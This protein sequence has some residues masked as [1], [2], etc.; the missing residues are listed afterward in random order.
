MT[1]KIGS[2]VIQKKLTHFGFPVIQNKLKF[3]SKEE[4]AKEL[5]RKSVSNV[6]YTGDRISLTFDGERISNKI[7]VVQH[8]VWTGSWSRK[9][10]VVYIDNDVPEKLRK[11]LAIHESVEKYLKEKYGL[12]PNNEAH[13]AAE[14]IERREFLRQHSQKEWDE[15]SKIAEIVHRKELSWLK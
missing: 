13:F 7:S 10:P 8:E 9:R 5:S 1:S 14:D 4:L 3:K 12:D 2:D 11:S 6:W 15:Y